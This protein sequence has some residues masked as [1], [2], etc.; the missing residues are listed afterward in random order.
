MEATMSRKPRKVIDK[1][2]EAMLDELIKGIENP[3]D[4]TSISD[5][6][7]DLKKNLIERMLSGELTHHLGYDKHQK[8]SS[9]Q[10]NSRNGH[11]SKT[12][13][14]DDHEVMIDVP[15]DR[16]SSFNPV[17]LPKGMRRLEGFD[18]KVISMYARGM[19]V[20]EIQGH[21][22]DI[23]Q[24]EV[25]PDLISTITDEVLADV[26]EWQNRPLEKLYT[27]VVF[28]WFVI[29]GYYILIALVSSECFG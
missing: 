1:A 21:L 15:R 7:K 18:E 19:S 29:Y 23:Y 2:K 22:K 16:D 20:R 8:R 13:L 6:F 10:D 9:E 25:S 28:G 17:I 27:L 11:S 3:Q 26:R 5:F 4:M 12:V 14:L 24:V